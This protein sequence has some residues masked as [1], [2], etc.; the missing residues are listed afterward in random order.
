MRKQVFFGTF[1]SS[2]SPQQL[3]YLYE[4]A[5][6]V[7]DK[8]RIAK[9]DKGCKTVQDAKGVLSNLSWRFDEVDFHLPKP[10]QF[11]FPGFVGTLLT[12]SQH[13]L[14]SATDAKQ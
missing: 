14:S 4:T 9:I 13:T 8:G 7:D 6:F 11:Y 5:I 12:P 2:K 10:G 1:I 3:E